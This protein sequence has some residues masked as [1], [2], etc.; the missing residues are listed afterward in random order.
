MVVFECRSGARGVRR[1]GRS[2]CVHVVRALIVTPDGLPLAR[3]AIAGSA[4]DKTSLW[5]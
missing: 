5:E 4:S 2:D 1:F 3:E